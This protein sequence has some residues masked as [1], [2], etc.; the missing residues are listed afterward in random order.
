[1]HSMSGCIDGISAAVLFV[2][3]SSSVSTG[4]QTKLYWTE[5]RAE[6]AFVM[7]ANGDGTNPKEIVS[8]AANIMGPNGLEYGNGFLYWPDQQ[9]NVISKV[10]PDGSELAVF[11]IVTNAY[12]V[13]IASDRVYW[14]ARGPTGISRIL[15]S[16]KLDGS[17][18]TIAGPKPAVRPFAVEVTDSFI[19]W[20]QINST[21]SAILSYDRNKKM[22]GLFAA[23][24]VM[25]YDMQLVGDFMYF[26]DN[27]T[28]ASIKK[29]NVTEPA[30]V[31][32]ANL[33]TILPVNFL[34]GLCVTKDAIYWS[35][36]N[37]IWRAGLNGENPTALYTPANTQ[38]RGV[39]LLQEGSGTPQP[40]LEDARRVDNNLIFILQGTAGKTLQVEKASG[41]T[42]A[43]SPVTNVLAANQPVSITNQIG[44]SLKSEIFRAKEL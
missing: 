24:S 20:S 10:R 31:T 26:G 19:Y 18:S 38:V 17:D 2:V 41:F 14:T 9:L 27:N 11:T 25:V 8:G 28:P 36:L 21:G 37:S 12:D 15:N 1:M 5:T 22:N 42:A 30:D 39:V 3:L 29:V 40:S 44:P 6:G 43:W 33:K 7:S 4:A 34:H 23:F 32:G 35:D 13:F 16:A